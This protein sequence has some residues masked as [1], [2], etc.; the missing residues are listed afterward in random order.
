MELPKIPKEQLTKSL[1]E[2]VGDNDVEF[3]SIV[4]PSDIIDIQI[5]P[6][7][8]YEGR[9]KAAEMLIESRKKLNEI[10]RNDQSSKKNY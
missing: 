6:D 5:D 1:R 7:A 8:Y 4:D 10:K 9:L 2:I 3:D